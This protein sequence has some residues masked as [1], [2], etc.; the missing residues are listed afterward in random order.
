M[1]T[2]FMAIATKTI[3]LESASAKLNLRALEDFARVARQA[4]GLIGEV[5]VLI[6]SDAEI[7]RLNTRFRGKNSS[8][9]V[10]SFPA[11]QANGFSGDIAISLDIAARNAQK[12]E[13]SV[14]D[15]I[16][17]LILH[18]ILHLA[19]YDHENDHGEMER[20]EMGLRRKLGLPAGLIERSFTHEPPVRHR[21]QTGRKLKTSARRKTQ[22]ARR[23]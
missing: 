7:R 10:L 16:R 5:S 17:I 4:V 2:S 15:E 18:G 23:T 21:L 6:T 19:G 11:G 9:D 22:G 3:V 13:H 14:Q 1:V 8:T 20:L 12:L